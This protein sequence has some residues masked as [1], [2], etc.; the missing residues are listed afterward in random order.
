MSDTLYAANQ[1]LSVIS[2]LDDD[3]ARE[4]TVLYLRS[5]NNMTAQIEGMEVDCPAI[6]RAVT[7]TDPRVAGITAADWE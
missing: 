4:F 5:L 2:N 6:L 3:D 1:I 7:E